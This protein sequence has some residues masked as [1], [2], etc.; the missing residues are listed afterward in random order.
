MKET[1][2]ILSGEQTKKYAIMHTYC[3]FVQLMHQAHSM[4]YWE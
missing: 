4:I 3:M 1:A 2:P